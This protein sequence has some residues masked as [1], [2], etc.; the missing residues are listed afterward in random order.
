MTDYSPEPF[1]GM[2][3]WLGRETGSWILNA[4]ASESQAIAW[5]E[6]KSFEASRFR[7]VWKVTLDRVTRQKLITPSQ[8][9]FEDY[10]G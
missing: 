1:T 2:E 4:W 6:E 9:Y 3:L 10:R 8:P 7:V 5:A